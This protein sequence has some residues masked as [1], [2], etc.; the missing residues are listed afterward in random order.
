MASA[1][2]KG[3]CTSCRNQ[4]SE[5][6]PATSR[7]DS[8]SLLCRECADLEAFNHYIKFWDHGLPE[9]NKGEVSWSNAKQS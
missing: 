7:K 9:L 2:Y 3:V 8:K 6:Y 4:I 5:R 1:F